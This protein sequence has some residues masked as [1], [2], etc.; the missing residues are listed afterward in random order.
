MH[1]VSLLLIYYYACIII[2]RD[3]EEPVVSVDDYYCL[4]SVIDENCP[5]KRTHGLFKSNLVAL[6]TVHPDRH[7]NGKLCR[8]N[9][10]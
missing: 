2:Y 9:N 1:G 5:V 8:D 3:S 4:K 7:K 10:I 6:S